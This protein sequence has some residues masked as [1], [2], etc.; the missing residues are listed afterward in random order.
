MAP[1]PGETVGMV[2][3]SNPDGAVRAALALDRAGRVPEAIAAYEAVLARWP[4][5][6][7]IWYN[8]AVLRRRLRQFEPAL[9]A[10]GEALARGV[11]RPEEVHLNR[12]VIYADFLRRDVDAERELHAALSLNPRFIPALLNLGNL[13]EDLGRRDDA[14]GLYERILAL[15]PTSHEALARLANVTDARVPAPTL[16]ARLE[17]ALADPATGAAERASLGFALGRLR[18]G[19]GEYAAAF[20]A[21][22]DANRASRASAAPGTPSYDRKRQE[23][24]ID[25]LIGAPVPVRPPSARDRAGPTPVFILG[26]HR[27]GSTLIEQLLAAHTGVAAG[28]ELDLLPRFAARELAPFPASLAAVTPAQ[29]EGLATRY[30]DEIA[31]L[32]PGAGTVTDKRPDNFLAIGLIKSLFPAARIV[33]T[34]RDP[35]DT[36]LSIYF[37][38]LDHGMGYALDLMDIG[39]YFREYRRLMRHW[40]MR[41]GADIYDLDY[42]RLVVAPEATVGALCQFLG[43][44]AAAAPGHD[45]AQGR[46]VKT[47]SVWQVREPIYKRSSGRAANYAAELAPLRRYLAGAIE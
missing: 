36:C 27:S 42:D 10:Y 25:R 46:A 40:K 23:E 47:A 17:R 44:D 4:A 38:H 6:A 14:R 37:L 26:M 15:D 39:H 43:I 24:W 12:A 21:Y 34:V 13:N 35:L 1:C 31:R 7:D 11:V 19:A 2:D 28:G 20:Q 5:L 18:D 32:F 16:I 41:F 45:R 30:L 22:A 29:L 9:A 3:S 33:H 8:L